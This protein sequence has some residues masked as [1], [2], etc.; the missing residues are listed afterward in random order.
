MAQHDYSIANASGL[1][2]RQD[3]NAALAAIK[4]LNSGATAPVSPV[5]GMFWLDTSA[6]PPELR[7]RNAANTGWVAL[8]NVNDGIADGGSDPTQSNTYG[9][10]KAILKTASPIEL[11]ANDTDETLTIKA[12]DVVV[13][14]DLKGVIGI[15]FQ[16]T[17]PYTFSATDPTALTNPFTARVRD[18]ASSG[19]DLTL[20]NSSCKAVL[21]VWPTNAAASAGVLTV[22]DWV[23]LSVT[24]NDPP[25]EVL[26]PIAALETSGNLL[27]V[28][29]GTEVWFSNDNSWSSFNDITGTGTAQVRK[30][31]LTQL[32]RAFTTV[33]EVLGGSNVGQFGSTA[34]AALRNAILGPDAPTIVISGL[35]RQ[36]GSTLPSGGANYGYNIIGNTLYVSNNPSAGQATF[37]QYLIGGIQLEMSWTANSDTVTWVFVAE[38]PIIESSNWFRVDIASTVSGT[39]PG[40]VN[41]VTLKVLPSVTAVKGPP[42]QDGRDGT[43]ASVTKASVAAVM[44]AG[45]NV[46]LDSSGSDLKVSAAVGLDT[47]VAPAGAVA[48]V[49]SG[50]TKSFRN[51]PINDMRAHILGPDTENLTIGTFTMTSSLPSVAGQAYASSGQINLTW[52]SAQE[53]EHLQS[54]FSAGERFRL[55]TSWEFQIPTPSVVNV[56]TIANGGI[57]TTYTTITGTPPTTGSVDLVVV[58]RLVRWSEFYG[59]LK[60][61][62]DSASGSAVTLTDD[63][64][65]EIIKWDI[66][67]ATISQKGAV[68]LTSGAGT[69][70]TQ[71]VTQAGAK[72]AAETYGSSSMTVK[73]EGQQLTTAATTIN[74]T[75]TG[76]TATASGN[77]VT[78]AV[79]PTGN[80]GNVNVAGTLTNVTT[81]WTD[82]VSGAS[83]DEFYV[84]NCVGSWSS[85]PGNVVSRSISF[86]FQDLDESTNTGNWPNSKWWLSLR[87]GTGGARFQLRRVATG[88]KIQVNR[89]GAVSSNNKVTAYRISPGAPGPQGP[90]GPSWV[91]QSGGNPVTGDTNTLNFTGDG[92]SVSGSGSTT[93][94]VNFDWPA[95]YELP[96]ASTSTKGGV[97]LA[98]N[99]EVEEVNTTKTGLV[100]TPAGA[101]AG[102]KDWIRASG[103]ITV[104][105]NDTAKTITIGGGG[106]NYAL[107]TATTSVKGGVVLATNSEVEDVNT[108]KAGLVVTPAGAFAGVK[109]W[110]KTSGN[111]TVTTDDTAKT[112]TIGSTN[113]NYV[114]PTASTSGKGGVVLATN[115]EVENVNTLKAGLVVTPAGAFAGVKDWIRASGNISVTTD[116]D[117][118]TITIT[119]SANNYTLPT[120]TTSGKGGVF[121]ATNSE[122]EDVNTSKA[123]LVVTPA[124]VFAGVSEWIRG[125]GNI[126]V[127][128]DTNANTI[129]IGG[130][131]GGSD[132]ELPTATT[133]T[134][135]GVELATTSEVEDVNT[136]AGLVV[137]PEGAW[138]AAKSW[139]RAGSNV[140]IS[141]SESNKTITINSTASGGGGGGG[142]NDIEVY[143]GSTKLTDAVDE[144]VFRDN[145]TAT[146]I[147]GTDG[148]RVDVSTATTNTKGVVELASKTDSDVLK[149]TS[150]TT[151]LTPDAMWGA[152]KSALV[153]GDYVGV[154]ANDAT[155]RITL[156]L[157]KVPSIQVGGFIQDFERGYGLTSGGRNATCVK[158]GS[159]NY[160]YTTDSAYMY[161]YE[162]TADGLVYN[163]SRSASLQR[164]ASWYGIMTMVDGGK[165]YVYLANYVTN[166]T[167][168][169]DCYE[170][171]STGI[172]YKSERSFANKLNE[173]LR[174]MTLLD[175]G[176]NKYIY[177]IYNRSGYNKIECFKITSTSI[178]EVNA[179]DIPGSKFTTFPSSIKFLK[180][181][182][183]NYLY[184]QGSRGL[185]EC[186][187]VTSSLVARAQN[188]EAA[189]VA[190]YGIGPYGLAFIQDGSTTYAYNTFISGARKVRCYEVLGGGK[191]GWDTSS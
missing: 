147:T 45:D 60:K 110:I 162:I 151:A 185:F 33:P 38:T 102:V 71:A 51:W 139:I 31:A 63:D 84:V 5:T 67:D 129:T 105:T 49:D 100:V 178:I 76:V 121:L 85:E 174:D 6:T 134:L 124:G 10:A 91:I 1:A 168:Y 23:L 20:P 101:F 90:P 118:K 138:E 130:G 136:K 47:E 141:R 179:R 160:L 163:T 186:Y 25:D 161:C 30:D 116:D 126:T 165:N 14:K 94:V 175:D 53:K 115:S 182:G 48:E 135:G 35:Q 146:K 119:T 72:L 9:P 137:T 173:Y 123:G 29:L 140:T 37:R 81:T 73:D 154:S 96:T 148:V 107:P 120:A 89:A 144:F 88:G 18:V 99:S 189:N 28:W 36:S 69:G 26:A 17:V 54:Y 181:Q 21:V 13:D 169:L 104:T 171:N 187:E 149:P 87:G 57:S 112:I 172:V 95:E 7:V 58:G 166:S 183:N 82:L 34:T 113:N 158:D 43:D 79:S 59:G 150:T 39:A 145:I 41:N 32:S 125:S 109:D 83:N 191:P 92:V 176:T 64:T 167:R 106:N 180:A 56:N 188:R 80:V 55:G 22:G 133:S 3:L 27:R 44:S 66:Q 143:N 46:Q 75:G 156:G 131:S 74:F 177:T 86:L 61:R 155:R 153:A 52:S 70:T 190:Y 15:L 62:L 2:F 114:L 157:T 98:T 11:T 40:Q 16:R 103:T 170:V 24:S 8:F 142:G 93:K 65:G 122:V 152:L 127:T 159:K 97:F 78:V 19:F 164:S 68:Q 4:S 111:V 108:T 184:A 42:G 12:P 50:G 77:E 117:A 132:Y 128:T